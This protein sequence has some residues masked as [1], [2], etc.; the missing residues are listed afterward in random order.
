MN[1]V[2]DLIGRML[3]TCRI[4]QMVGQ[5][6]MGIVYLAQQTRPIRRVAVKLLLPEANLRTQVYQQFLLRFQQQLSVSVELCY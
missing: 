1:N 5:G 4:E 2:N 3:G 6:G